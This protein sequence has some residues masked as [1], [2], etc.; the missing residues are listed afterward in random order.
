MMTMMLMI[1]MT[2][3]M[4]IQDDDDD[5]SD[6]DDSDGLEDDGSMNYLPLLAA[7]EHRTGLPHPR[8]LGSQQ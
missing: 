4:M 8:R 3:M 6:D 7:D 2:M 5:D 1:V